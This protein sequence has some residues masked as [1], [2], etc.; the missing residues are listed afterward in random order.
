MKIIITGEKKHIETLIWENRI[1]VSRKLLTITEESQEEKELHSDGK[2]TKAIQ[3]PTDSKK[4]G[5]PA[6]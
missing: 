5:R 2:D 1:R 6:Q 3:V 4:R